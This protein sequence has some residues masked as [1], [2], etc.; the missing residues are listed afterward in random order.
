MCLLVED[1]VRLDLVRVILRSK[2]CTQIFRDPEKPNSLHLLA[3]PFPQSI[4][5]NAEGNKIRGDENCFLGI[6]I[7][8]NPDNPVI[9]II[10]ADTDNQNKPLNYTSPPSH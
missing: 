6:D 10:P 1:K 9:Y 3:N 2:V 4:I 5:I 8:A 7:H